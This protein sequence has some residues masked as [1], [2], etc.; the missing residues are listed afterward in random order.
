MMISPVKPI[1]FG[2]N[3]SIKPNTINPTP[4]AAITC[5]IKMRKWTSNQ[6]AKFTKVNSSRISH[7]PLFSKKLR[8]EAT[9]FLFN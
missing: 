4:I 2:D 1:T 3:F 8:V 5:I 6:S 7:P 9:V